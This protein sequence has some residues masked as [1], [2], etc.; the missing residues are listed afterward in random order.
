MKIKIILLVILMIILWA[1][2]AMA[3]ELSELPEF[4]YKMQTYEPTSSRYNWDTHDALNVVLIVIDWKQT[5]KMDELNGELYFIPEVG[6]KRHS[7]S[8]KNPILGEDPT[9]NEINTY[10]AL[11]LITYGYLKHK[12]YES[13]KWMKFFK[14]YRWYI[15]TIEIY[16]I[17]NN[18]RLGIRI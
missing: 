15:T 13:N 5:L 6:W 17:D 10:F 12:S 9:Q 16:C 18:Y 4:E 3:I 11:S 7:Y 14:Y 8:E 1:S 2:P